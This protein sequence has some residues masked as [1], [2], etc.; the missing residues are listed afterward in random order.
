MVWKKLEEGKFKDMLIKK[1]LDAHT[2]WSRLRT[3]EEVPAKQL[4]FCWKRYTEQRPEEL[5]SNPRVIIG[6]LIHRGIEHYFGQADSEDSVIKKQ[7]NEY[8]VVG[9]PDYM[10]E[11]TVYEFKYSSSPPREP[12]DWDIAQ[13]RIYMWM[14]GKQK[15]ELVYITPMRIKSFIIDEPMTDEE[16]QHLL[17]YRWAKYK[18]ECSTCQFR[19]ECKH[20]LI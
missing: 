18:W 17:R 5:L 12:K 20:S 11:N 13:L 4:V 8:V 7:M 3:L 9:L 10:T 6:T 2:H 16:I 15:G 19:H 14:T 1:L